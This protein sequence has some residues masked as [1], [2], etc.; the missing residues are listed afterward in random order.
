M[1]S[2]WT[3]RPDKEILDKLILAQKSETDRAKRLALIKKVYAQ[4][5]VYPGGNILFGLNMIYAMRD[6]IDYVYP[7]K[8]GFPF[9]LQ[10]IKI[11]K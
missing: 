8:E 1:A 10:R 11:L 4:M 7:K 2:S 9:H 3:T 5:R 6:R